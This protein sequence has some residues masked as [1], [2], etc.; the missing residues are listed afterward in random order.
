[1]KISSED[2]E[3]NLPVFRNAV[4]SSAVD[5]L[6]HASREHQDWFDENDDEI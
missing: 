1:M 4:H 2:P 3:E 6:G 5:T